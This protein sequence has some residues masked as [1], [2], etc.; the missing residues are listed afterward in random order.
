MEHK[1][2]SKKVLY[3]NFKKPRLRGRPKNRWQDKVR[4]D[5][6]RCGGKGWKESVYN[7]QE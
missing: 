4:V 7:R 6:R 5:G 3:I 2:I 1:T